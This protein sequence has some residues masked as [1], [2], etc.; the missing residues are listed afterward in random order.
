[1]S[2]SNGLDFASTPFELFDSFPSFK[3][4]KD[5]ILP[6]DFKLINN[7]KTTSKLSHNGLYIPYSVDNSIYKN[8][9]TKA[10]DDLSAISSLLNNTQNQSTALNTTNT[11]TLINKSNKK[12]IH[13]I[14]QTED[15]MCIY[16]GT[17]LDKFE[18]KGLLQVYSTYTQTDHN[19]DLSTNTTKDNSTINL[20][21][22]TS[23]TRN[24]IQTIETNPNLTTNS[25]NTNSN[26]NNSNTKYVIGNENI[27]SVKCTIPFPP[28]LAPSDVSSQDISSFQPT[29]SVQ[30]PSS[31]QPSPPPPQYS[32][33]LKYYIAPAF[34]VIILKATSQVQDTL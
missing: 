24:S 13:K 17:E 30:P 21:I 10:S 16:K 18:I 12:I 8:K 34:K 1:M 7:N 15:I 27:Y 3:Q 2:L 23:G 14:K 25:T 4:S 6:D 20:T 33:V 28:T 32:S 19:S 22:K 29:S 5:T 31:F 26:T 11:N 9:P